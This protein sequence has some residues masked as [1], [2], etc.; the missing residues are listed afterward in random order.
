MAQRIWVGLG[1]VAWAT[2]A[3]AQPVDMA[4]RDLAHETHF[5]W[6]KR[7][8]YALPDG[9]KGTG[10]AVLASFPAGYQVTLRDYVCRASS[11]VVAKVGSARPVASAD[12]LLIFT[13]YSVEI[14]RVI[15][16]TNAIESLNARMRRATRA[17]GHFPNEQAALKCLYLTIASTPPDAERTAG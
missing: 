10:P 17:R 6:A 9:T 12:G 2:V 5:A 1:V 8:A 14:R 7:R 4:A 3:F 16:S 11:I 13:D 15:Y